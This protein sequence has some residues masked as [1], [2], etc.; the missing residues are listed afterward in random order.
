MT[1][2]N[3]KKI[4]EAFSSNIDTSKKCAL[5]NEVGRRLTTEEIV[6]IHKSAS[7]A[8][9]RVAESLNEGLNVTK[10]DSQWAAEFINKTLEDR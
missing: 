3:I 2:A 8:F 4:S 9:R 10:N 6:E 7:A 5:W 1:R